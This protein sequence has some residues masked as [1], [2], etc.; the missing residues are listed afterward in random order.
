[1]RVPERDERGIGLAD[2]RRRVR[3]GLEPVFD[4]I[5]GDLQQRDRYARRC[6]LTVIAPA[7]FA[8]SWLMPRLCAF[9]R[10]APD[11]DLVI[12]DGFTRE[13]SGTEAADVS[14]E[15]GEF[16]AAEGAAVEKLADEELFPV[17]APSVRPEDGDLSRVTLLHCHASSRR[18]G[19]PDWRAFLEAVGLAVGAPDAGPRVSGTLILDAARAGCGVA[20]AVDT[21]A[22]D[23]LAA[24]RLVRPIP[25]SVRVSGGY[26]LR[27]G[28]AAAERP[29]VQAFHAWMR[30]EFAARCGPPPTA[31]SSATGRVH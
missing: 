27:L 28:Q 4:M 17:C 25:D 2:E 29:E 10:L 19:V 31:E 1:M 16:R 23:D 14:I 24:G 30:E 3:S 15:W 18:S 6:N 20:L 5:A 22:R 7:E 26:G 9:R 8:K 21:I 13:Q 12:A 11:V